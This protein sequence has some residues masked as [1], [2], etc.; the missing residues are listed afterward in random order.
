MVS[1]SDSH[2]WMQDYA[3]AGSQNLINLT[4]RSSSVAC[5]S[6]DFSIATPLWFR[7]I[8]Q[9]VE[10]RSP[11]PRVPGSSPG[12]PARIIRTFLLKLSPVASYWLKDRPDDRLDTSNSFPGVDTV[13][14]MTS[15]VE[16]RVF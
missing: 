4:G 13:F 2:R 11:K 6:V 5:N 14:D 3:G 7:G 1:P 12:A 9:L 16:V 10:H 15:N 8:A